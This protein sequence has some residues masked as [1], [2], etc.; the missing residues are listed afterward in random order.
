M[1]RSIR[2]MI[3][4]T[5]AAGF[6]LPAVVLLLP[7]RPEWPPLTLSTAGV[8]LAASAL[9]AGIVLLLT[10]RQDRSTSQSSLRHRDEIVE[11]SQSIIGALV[12]AADPVNDAAAR[13]VRRVQSMATEVAMAIGLPPADV[14]VV[15][16]AVL[17]RGLDAEQIERS[18]LPAPLARVIRSRYEKFDGT[19][20]PDGL[21]GEAIPAAARVLG[22]VERYESLL[23]GPAGGT[24][25]VP[26]QALAD[27]RDE[28]GTTCDPEVVRLLITTAQRLDGA[29]ED[30]AAAAPGADATSPASDPL[31]RLPAASQ[32]FSSFEQELR[33]A[34]QQKSTLSLIELDVDG[35]G[36]INERYGRQ[37]GDRVL[38]GLARAIRGQMRP[39]DTCVRYAGDQ[40]LLILTGVAAD[41]I[42][43]VATRLEQG[44]LRHKFAVARNTAIAVDVTLGSASFPA[45][46]RTCEDLIAIADARMRQRKLTRRGRAAESDLQFH[47]PGPRDIPVN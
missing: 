38:R 12:F 43:A 36:E 3:A 39:G 33:R 28:A 29:Q 5:V 24:P 4:L 10:L 6:L 23:A 45:D 19:G 8:A 30:G 47:S 31:T 13:R 15:R 1:S 21:R 37:A 7:H 2:L 40:F 17:L 16:A 46:G 26:S 11:T 27:L 14:A 35:F 41:R 18:R 20:G 9:T 22:A 32:L 25:A 42:D 44:V 34:A